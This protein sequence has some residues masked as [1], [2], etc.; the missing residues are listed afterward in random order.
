MEK[1]KT[2]YLLVIGLLT[3]FGVMQG[4]SGYSNYV[5]GYNESP[6]RNFPL[7]VGAW[8]GQKY[9]MKEQVY[10]ILE[11]D[12]VIM[13][14]YK[15]GTDLVVQSIVH[16]SDEK[17]DFHRPESCNVGK[18]DKVE[19]EQIKSI[20]LNLGDK[21]TPIKVKSFIVER[22]KES[23]KLIY[24]F[25]KSEKFIGPNYLNF[26]YNLGLNYFRNRKTSGSLIILT[27]PIISDT[28]SAEST[29]RN[30]MESFY[31]LWTQYI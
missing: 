27:T 23:K 9:K 1:I 12:A 31:P 30:F 15:K 16:Y 26:R 28:P 4:S 2:R 20:M 3:I 19:G 10:Q 13:N 18:G 24:Y 17:V 29:L 6:L 22:N 14:A 25:F 5:R 7:N 8:S 11:T 21:K